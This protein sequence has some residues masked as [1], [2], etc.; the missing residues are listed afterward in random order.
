MLLQSQV[1]ED[2]LLLQL[3]VQMTRV[4]SAVG[5][6]INEVVFQHHKRQLLQFCPGFGP[7]KAQG[8]IKVQVAIH[9]RA[10]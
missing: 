10:F 8:L 5:V 9:A 7:A 3:Y 1:S 6:D 2:V 4:V